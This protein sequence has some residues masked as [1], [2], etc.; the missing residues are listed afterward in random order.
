LAT[1]E[2]LVHI[3]LEF[4]WKAWLRQGVLAA[5][6]APQSPG[7]ATVSLVSP[8]AAWESA[9]APPRV[10]T[11][12]KRFPALDTPEIVARL[13]Q[14]EWLVR[15]E[16][17]DRPT[18]DEFRERFPQLAAGSSSLES[19]LGADA[20]A[21]TV[22]AQWQA[23]P[24]HAAKTPA[25]GAATGW[26]RRFGN[27]EL[28]GEIGRGGMGVVYRARQIAANRIVALKVLR[29][30]LL[31]SS[32]HET[33]SSPLDRFHHEVQ[34]AARLQH[35]HIVT[36]Y[37]AG[38]IE[39]EPFFSMRYVEGRSL[40]EI[41]RTGPIP[42]RRAAAYLAPVARA[43][44]EAHR[45]GILHRDLKPQNILVDAQSD[46]PLVADFGLAKLV[47]ASDDLTEAGQIMGSPPYMSPEQAKDSARV[48]AQTDVYALGATLYH[49]LTGRPP[50]QAATAVETLRQ[51]VS[52]EPAPP[53]RLNPS[54]DRDL[55]TICVKCLQKEPARRYESAQ[56]LAEDLE[57][58]LRGEPI[59]ARPVGAWERTVRWCRR[60]PITAALVGS[61]AA[62]FLLALIASA[63][64][65]WQT[66]AALRES[67]ASYRQAR[68]MLN[69]FFTRVSEDTV[70]N[71][72]GMQPL[73]RDLLAQA[74]DY[75]DRFLER[76]RDDPTIR[77]ELALTHFRVGRIVEEMGD[78]PR[79]QAA[80]RQALDAQQ[81]LAAQ[82]PD[83]LDRLQAVGN[84]YN[85][86]GSLLCRMKRFDDSQQAHE[87]AADVRRRLAAAE[88]QRVEFQ[89]TLANSLMNIGNVEERRGRFAQARRQYAEAQQVR[90]A[91]R[92]ADARNREVARDLAM[93]CFNLG[94]LAFADQDLAAAETEFDEAIALFQELHDPKR[95]D[96]ANQYRLAFAQRLAADV[97]QARGKFDEAQELYQAAIALV[98]AL[99]T[100]NPEVPEYQAAKAGLYVSLGKLHTERRQS[101]E[102]IAA[103]EQARGAFGALAKEFP[104][105][106]EYHRDLAVT[107][108]NLGRELAAAG[109]ADA[110]HAHLG[111]AKTQLLAL[112]GDYPENP[113]FA[114]L[115]AEV[116]RDLAEL[117]SP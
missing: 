107:L 74:L 49:V 68:V 59:R 61:T 92:R 88:P 81:A 29:R 87:A 31:R 9:P 66:S 97:R 67:D 16:H 60:N 23:H 76:R 45:Q 48:N 93:G 116:E 24:P 3:E 72:P 10:E 73:R 52:D 99:A 101:A 114:D 36:V 35:D 28:L 42:N 91:L 55:E 58:Y 12:L 105:N 86:L 25:V 21:E 50:F 17:G 53:R 13:V 69:D 44:A 80:Y 5:T 117:G 11:Y 26:P 113:E 104:S 47:G 78:W 18:V 37:E 103:L 14:Q 15:R 56:S 108:H 70:L 38:E 1:L 95:R 2:E 98:S 30:E 33:R 71:E 100:A 77:D 90:R 85:A 79:A 111:E 41:L 34:A 19:L 4:A 94:K 46:R 62:F 32:L 6:A 22:A 82:S 106:V 65:Y 40:S 89:R 8:P 84:T 75:Y 57:R 110:A 20:P 27:Y 112:R 102:T 54:I 96:L 43:I 109:K 63:V 51:V 115:L 83:D 39:G 64:G 7:A